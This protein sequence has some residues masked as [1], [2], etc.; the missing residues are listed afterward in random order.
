MNSFSNHYMCCV[1]YVSKIAHMQK[2]IKSKTCAKLI[3]SER[4]KRNDKWLHGCK[5][6]DLA[7]LFWSGN[8]ENS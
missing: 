2:S 8:E 6:L 7:F 1:C 5:F 3:E 4:K